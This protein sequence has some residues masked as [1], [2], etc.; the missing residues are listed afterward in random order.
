MEGKEDY[1]DGYGSRSGYS[2]YGTSGYA[3]HL[4]NSRLANRSSASITENGSVSP[5]SS[6]HLQI[7]SPR[8]VSGGEC[9]HR[10]RPTM[11]SSVDSGE[12]M[13]FIGKPMGRSIMIISTR[14]HSD[15]RKVTPCWNRI[16]YH[17]SSRT[18]KRD[19]Q[20]PSR[21]LQNQFD[22]GYRLDPRRV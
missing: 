18:S 1:R 20:A 22:Q 9:T 4:S 7:A 11:P 12:I 13:L 2:T 19:Q 21:T 17:L 14:H 10:E 5:S 15:P 16:L 8:T 3:A 6:G